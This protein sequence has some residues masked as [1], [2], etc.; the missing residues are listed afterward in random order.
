MGSFLFGLLVS[1]MCWYFL[2]HY[3]TIPE[4]WK[5]CIVFLILWLI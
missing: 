1:A 3:T 2:D 5:W 4:F